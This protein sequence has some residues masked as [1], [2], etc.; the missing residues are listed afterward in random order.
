MSNV[1]TTNSDDAPEQQSPEYW[2][3]LIDEK[4][5]AAFLGLSVRTI[6]AFRVK[7]GGAQYVRI[8]ARCIRY[9]RSD[10]RSWFEARLRSSTSDF[11]PEPRDE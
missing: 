5:A 9:R 11:G 3:S 7:G 2:Q 1:V 10:L 4:D 6:Q 8:S